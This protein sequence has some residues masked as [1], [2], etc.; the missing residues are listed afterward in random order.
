MTNSWDDV[1]YTPSVD[2][3]YLDEYKFGWSRYHYALE[4]LEQNE[5]QHHLLINEL[6]KSVLEYV[7]KLIF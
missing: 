1:F 4:E 5:D 3:F 6:Q 2:N 7:E